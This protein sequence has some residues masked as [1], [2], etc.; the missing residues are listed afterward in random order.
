M[1]VKRFVSVVLAVAV[2]LVGVAPMGV[3]AA[4]S[5]DDFDC[6]YH[7]PEDPDC[8]GKMEQPGPDDIDTPGEDSSNSG[9]LIG[10]L[11]DLVG[12]LF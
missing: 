6:Q 11:I 10:A 4:E 1:T 3:A 2:L 8:D 5:G 7:I 9:G 12:T